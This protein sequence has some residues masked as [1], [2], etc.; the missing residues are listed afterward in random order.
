MPP[1]VTE[2]VVVATMPSPVI[3]A[4]V[5]PVP[6]PLEPLIA[7]MPVIVSV[8]PVLI[9][10]H[11]PRVLELVLR[12]LI[13]R[14]LTVA[15]APSAGWL[16]GTKFP[17]MTSSPEPGTPLGVQL[18]A[19]FQLLVPDVPPTQVFVAAATYGPTIGPPL[20]LGVAPAGSIESVDVSAMARSRFR[21]PLPV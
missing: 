21:R 10:R 2:P 6:P 20:P 18:L 12:P 3:P 14:L 4:H 16:P 8:K 11:P 5:V 1:T 9:V 19:T 7:R 15:L 17:M 13:V